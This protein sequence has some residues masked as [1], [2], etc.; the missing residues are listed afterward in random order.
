MGVLIILLVLAFVGWNTFVQIAARQQTNISCSFDTITASRIVA[1][2]FG[3]WWKEVP[4]RGDDN[5]K[6]RRGSNAPTLSISYKVGDIGGCDVD[7]W[8]SQG[9]TRYGLLHHAQLAWRK[10]HAVVRALARAEL[11]RSP[12][13]IEPAGTATVS[14]AAPIRQAPAQSATES[15]K[16][17]SLVDADR[18]PTR[19]TGTSIA[20]GSVQ[21]LQPAPVT[22]LS[23]TKSAS[24]MAPP[25]QPSALPETRL[26]GRHS[27]P[28]DGVGVPAVG[29]PV[30]RTLPLPIQEILNGARAESVPADGR[31]RDGREVGSTGGSDIIQAW[32]KELEAAQPQHGPLLQNT[33]DRVG[34]LPAVGDD[35]IIYT[36][37]H[38]RYWYAAGYARSFASLQADNRRISAVLAEA[39][40]R[41]S[42][43][44]H[45]MVRKEAEAAFWET[46]QQWVDSAAP[47]RV[48]PDVVPGWLASF[49]PVW[50][51]AES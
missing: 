15:L 13:L 31:M 51:P 30:T 19:T 20:A 7:I 36:V 25:R 12:A 4:G 17:L 22:G 18:V 46:V 27:R 38:D 9:T 43:D 44:E 41:E 48:T 23:M 50:N 47:A 37:S 10:K 28:D 2:S 32:L 35:G 1:D 49:R 29:R 26:R 14:A 6:A 11:D 16:R 45:T 33:L 40:A 21:P 5:R 8:C 39:R 3:M 34:N 24:P 42:R